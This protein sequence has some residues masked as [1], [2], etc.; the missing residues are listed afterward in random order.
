MTLPLDQLLA[1]LSDLLPVIAAACCYRRLNTILKLTAAYAC[2][3]TVSDAVQTVCFFLRV[4]NNYPVIHIYLLSSI[5]LCGAIYYHAFNSRALKKVVGGVVAITFIISIINVIFIEHLFAYPSITNAVSGVM[6]IILSLLYFGMLLTEKDTGIEKQGFFWINA[7]MLFY[8]S[9]TI[10]LFM[11][12]KWLT[13]QQWSHYYVINSL[14]NIIANVL[15]T[16][17]LLCKPHQTT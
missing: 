7:A 13:P 3:G 1:T 16:I 11:L 6:V 9:I 14:T 8:F 4:H 5:L 15:F 17:G 10:F 2:L 12:Y